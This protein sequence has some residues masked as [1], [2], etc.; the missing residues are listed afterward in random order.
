MCV[1]VCVKSVMVAFSPGCYVL[2]SFLT[3]LMVYFDT[4]SELF[5]V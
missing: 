4:H 1:C 2:L 3:V 5:G